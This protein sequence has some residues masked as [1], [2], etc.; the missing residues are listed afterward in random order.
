MLTTIIFIL[1]LVALIGLAFFL[2]NLR[3][4]RAIKTVVKLFRE[5]KALDETRAKTPSEMGIRPQTVVERLYKTRDYKP[6]ALQLLMQAQIVESVEEEKLY[7]SES[8]LSN[9]NIKKIVDGVES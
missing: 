4:K 8:K 5:H 6:Y 9:S 7:L 2:S 1:V 3:M